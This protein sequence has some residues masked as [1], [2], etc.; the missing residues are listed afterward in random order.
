M[1]ACRS[2][3]KLLQ[4]NTDALALSGPP[5]ETLP[6]PEA[7]RTEHLQKVGLAYYLSLIGEV[8]IASCC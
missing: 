1:T 2:V 8:C 5:H 4:Q 6:P 3:Y 7:L